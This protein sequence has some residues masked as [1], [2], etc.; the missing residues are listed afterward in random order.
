MLEA[1]GFLMGVSYFLQGTG[2][3]WEK[4][5]PCALSAVSPVLCVGERWREDC[6]GRHSSLPD[7]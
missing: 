6:P 4:V 5:L 1:G 3:T 7:S 2:Q